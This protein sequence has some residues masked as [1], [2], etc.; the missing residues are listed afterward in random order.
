VLLLFAKIFSDGLACRLAVFLTKDRTF[1]NLQHCS[2][3]FTKKGVMKETWSEAVHT[4]TD[5]IFVS[6]G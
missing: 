6:L 4:L 5:F 2:F 1:Q 3:W